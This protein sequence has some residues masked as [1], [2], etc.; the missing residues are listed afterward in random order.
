[1]GLTVRLAA[2]CAHCLF[3]VP[4][5]HICTCRSYT[6]FSHLHKKI[7]ILG[8]N[9]CMHKSGCLKLESVA[10]NLALYVSSEIGIVNFNSTILLCACGTEFHACKESR[11]SIKIFCVVL[12]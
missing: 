4:N 2:N 6:Q 11:M 10:E 5:V 3:C 7:A 9:S 1:M 12:R 8:E